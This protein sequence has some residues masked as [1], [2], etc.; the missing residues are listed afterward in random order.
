MERKSIHRRFWTLHSVLVVGW[1]ALTPGCRDAGPGRSE[2]PTF[3]GDVAPIFFAR[4]APCHRPEGPG[5][6]SIT[7]YETARA[8]APRIAEVTAQR[9]MP[10]WLPAPG[11]GGLAD[12]RRLSDAEIATIGRW[13]ASGA[14]FGDSAELAAPPEWPSGWGLGPP[15]LV[16]ELLESY[17]LDPG[18]G[19]E[20]RNFV[21]PVPIEEGRW[22]RG[23]EMRPTN[24]RVV[25]HAMLMVD[26]SRST[27]RLDALDPRPGYDGMLSEGGARNPGGFLLGWTPGKVPSLTKEGLA[28]R[29]EPGTDLVVQLHLRP[30]ASE[31]QPVGLQVGLHFADDAPANTPFV[32]RLGSRT[33]DIEPG[34]A[35]HGFEDEY[36]LPV[37]VEALGVYPH[38]HYL[39]KTMEVWAKLP[40]GSDRWLLR[41]DDWDFN[42]QDVYRYA[43]PVPL[44]RGSVLRVRFT[45]D[46]SADNPRN[47]SSPP[48]RVIYGPG[49][50]DE[51]A[52]LWLQVVPRD[53]A[54]FLILSS[55]FAGKDRRDRVAGW[56]KTLELDP[57]DALAHSSLGAVYQA[58]DEL[59]PAEHHYRA[60]LRS[61]P[62][63]VPARYNLALLLESLGR[64]E[65]AMSEYRETIRVDPDHVDARNNLGTLLATGSRLREAAAQ[66]RAVIRLQPDHA[67]AHNN[68]GNVL[69]SQGRIDEAAVEFGAALALDPSYPEAHFNLGLT[70]GAQ[71]L[72]RESLASFRQ[73][74]RL[75]PNWPPPL[76][77]AAW[78]M[79]TRPGEL[80]GPAEAIAFAEQAVRLTGLGEASYLDVLA[81]AYASAG[82]F[83]RAVAAEERAIE[84]NQSGGRPQT[85]RAYRERLALYRQGRPYVV[86]SP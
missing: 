55:D 79:A 62:R 52:E 57:E 66:F 48:R 20:F 82:D 6:F 78:I 30:Q 12:E 44:P 70:Q 8:Y 86:P 35:D 24:P 34:A 38:A 9:Y 43:D 31:P 10:P 54:D 67:L 85:Q 63:L 71:G 14:S 3:S 22:I 11:V 41:I 4:C 28:W 23:M 42:W 15:D 61:E 65:E 74:A 39:G 36:V 75:R 83:A 1:I 40:D 58:Q 33:L 37:D 50:M 56:T 72:P 77:S 69:R 45:Y 80:S 81:A 7:D 73:A 51:M 21:I 64:L 27:R 68:L 60:A 13:A 53:S 29:L 5:P 26:P 59:D 76:I 46:N 84:L 19:E 32:L 16:V 18:V 2:S 49:S 47:P 25:H 17:E